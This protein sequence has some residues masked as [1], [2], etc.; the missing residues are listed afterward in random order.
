MKNN[1]VW[2]YGNDTET[3]YE[4]I[5]DY[6]IDCYSRYIKFTDEHGNRV[7]HSGNFTF[8]DESEE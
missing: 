8:I 3:L 2:I 6:E 1:L 7:V 5:T 4:N